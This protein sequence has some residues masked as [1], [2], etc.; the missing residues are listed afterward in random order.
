[1]CADYTIMMI[2]YFWEGMLC[3]QY[4]LFMDS[5]F[6]N[7]EY[8]NEYKKYCQTPLSRLKVPTP[9]TTEATVAA[10]GWK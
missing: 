5:G 6:V 4:L 3:D 7:E 1:M 2:V 9:I 10:T 8:P